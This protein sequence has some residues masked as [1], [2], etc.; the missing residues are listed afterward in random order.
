MLCRLGDL[1]DFALESDA[2]GVAAGRCRCCVPRKA[3]PPASR[4][5]DNSCSAIMAT[6]WSREPSISI[7][8][9]TSDELD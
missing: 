9:R 8:A 6:G 2:D 7:T 5:R 1:Y 3:R 4:P